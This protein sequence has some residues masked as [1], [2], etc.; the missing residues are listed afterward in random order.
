[1]T[2]SPANRIGQPAG[3]SYSDSGLAAGSYYYLVQAEDAAGNLSPSSN[4][5]TAAIAADTTAPSAPGGLAAS[6]SGTTATLNWSASTDNVGVVRYDV[7]RSTTSGFAP[8][9]AN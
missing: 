3:T 1:F 7:Y 2:P 6:V 9:A 4:Q 5:A 8:A